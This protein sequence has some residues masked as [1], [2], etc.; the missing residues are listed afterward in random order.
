MS[1]TRSTRA[2]AHIVVVDGESEW[3]RWLNAFQTSYEQDGITYPATPEGDFKTRMADS[4]GYTTGIL[5]AVRGDRAQSREGLHRTV[6]YHLGH[7]MMTGASRPDGMF[8]NAP[9]DALVTGFGNLVETM[10]MGSPSVMVYSY[11]ERNLN[12][13]QSWPEMVAERFRAGKITTVI[14]VWNFSTDTMEPEHYAE[15]WSMVSLLSEAED[16]FAQAVL[17]VQRGEGSM[18]EAVRAAYEIEDVRL[19]AGWRQWAG[20]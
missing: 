16:K 19:L 10:A 1:P 15:G 6:T 9:H 17:G 3:A 8:E 12:G 11:T 5:S 4:P 13:A 14:S 2:R 18:A 7:L 20:R